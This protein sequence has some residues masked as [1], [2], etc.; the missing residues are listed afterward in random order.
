MGP[1]GAFFFRVVF[2]L[3]FELC[4]ATG[5]KLGRFV[6]NQLKDFDFRGMLE[7]NMAN[8]CVKYIE[9]LAPAA[10]RRVIC[11][12]EGRTLLIL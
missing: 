12:V 7:A 2:F 10:N 8:I 3:L 11:W 4:F 9:K 6:G 5:R 1:L